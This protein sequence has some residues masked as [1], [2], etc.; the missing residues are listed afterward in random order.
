MKNILK[1]IT[2]IYLYW[3][4]SCDKR[5]FSFYK[6]ISTWHL[7]RT[8][9]K[10]PIFAYCTCNATQRR[11]L[12]IIIMVIRQFIYLRSPDTCKLEKILTSP[13]LSLI[14]STRLTYRFLSATFCDLCKKNKQI[15]ILLISPIFIILLPKLSILLIMLIVKQYWQCKLRVQLEKKLKNSIPTPNAEQACVWKAQIN[16]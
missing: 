3:M 12:E 2:E 9:L 10:K 1:R 16:Q 14:L 13:P 7:S 6:F 4:A 5:Y 15:F 11:K 8:W